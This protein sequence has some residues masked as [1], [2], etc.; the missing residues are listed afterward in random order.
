M[1]RVARLLEL[2]VRLQTRPR[3]TAGE[4]AAEFAVSRRTMLRDLQELSALGVPLVATP[5]R[6]GGYALAWPHRPPALALTEVEATGLVLAYEAFLGYAQTPFAPESLS[7]ITKLRA[8]LPAAAL[9]RL[10]RVRDRVAVVEPAPAAP[11]PLLPDLLTAAL[12]GR[13]LRIDYDSRSGRSE[14]TVW[15]IGLYAAAGFW[16]CACHD[17]RRGQVVSLRAD[18]VLALAPTEAAPRPPVPTLREWLRDRERGGDLLRFRARLTARGAKNFEVRSLFGPPTEEPDGTWTIAANVPAG[19]LGRYAERLLGVGPDLVVEE[20]PALVA[21][22]ADLAERVAALYRPP[23]KAADSLLG[24]KGVVL[25]TPR[26]CRSLACA[27]AAPRATGSHVAQQAVPRPCSPA[28][29]GLESR[30]R[31]RSGDA[32]GAAGHQENNDRRQ[33]DQQQRR[34]AG[35]DARLEA[36]GARPGAGRVG[37]VGEG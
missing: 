16:Y 30:C 24:R 19:E 14:R 12:D 21:A 23:A 1:A 13:P 4:L 17:E 26:G 37:R 31:R 9:G 27:L 32:D 34:Q 3:F 22:M 15:P 29:A 20:P 5:G 10:D 8:A 18:R 6:G 35:R 33:E 2:L 11:A 25:F 28:V 7:A 36:T